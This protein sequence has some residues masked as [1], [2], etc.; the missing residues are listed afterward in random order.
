[1]LSVW[2]ETDTDGGSSCV[3]SVKISQLLHC[4][5]SKARTHILSEPLSVPPRTHTLARSEAFTS[6]VVVAAQCALSEVQ[7]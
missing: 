4:V 3:V 6:T 1:M 5:P 7:K 2:S